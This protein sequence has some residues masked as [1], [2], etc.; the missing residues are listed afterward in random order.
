MKERWEGFG[1][2]KKGFLWEEEENLVFEVLMKNEAVL[3]WDDTEKGRFRED[4]FDPVIILTVKHKPWAL[5]YIP[6]LHGLRCK[7]A[8]LSCWRFVLVL[9]YR[10]SFIRCHSHC[11]QYLY[12]VAS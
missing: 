9:S 1:W 4:Y 11:S 10:L 7:R 6:I 3:A 12:S 2:R 8:L 5:R